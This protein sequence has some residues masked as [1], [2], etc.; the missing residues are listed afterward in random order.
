MNPE[1][2]I[3]RIKAL[4]LKRKWNLDNTTIYLNKN[5]DVVINTLLWKEFWLKVE[6]NN[7]KNASK[8]ADFLVEIIRNKI[9]KEIKIIILLKQETRI[10]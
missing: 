2:L 1:E 3:I 4:S 9:S 5:N 10:Y 6:N 7:W 8:C